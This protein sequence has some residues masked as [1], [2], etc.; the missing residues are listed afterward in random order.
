MKVVIDL[1]CEIITFETTGIGWSVLAVLSA[2]K[3]AIGF[4]E[5]AYGDQE[6]PKL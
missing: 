3:D 4:I 2:A 6:K 1:G 5:K